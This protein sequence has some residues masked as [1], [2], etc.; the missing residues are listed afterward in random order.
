M[1]GHSDGTTCPNCGAN[2]EQYTDRKPFDYTSIECYECGL[3]I[4]PVVFYMNLKE[5]NVK[6]KDLGLGPKR[7]LPEQD[8]DIF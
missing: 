6:R 5:L 7:K 3:L 8:E 4:A 1:S 2:A